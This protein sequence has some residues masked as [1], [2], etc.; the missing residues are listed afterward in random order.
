MP[1]QPA[2]RHGHVVHWGDGRKKPLSKDWVEQCQVILLSV[3][4]RAVEGVMRQLGPLLNPDHLVMDNCS[5]KAGPLESMR[6]HAPCAVH[7]VR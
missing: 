5:L 1:A 3:P 7:V 4:I 6:R 2:E